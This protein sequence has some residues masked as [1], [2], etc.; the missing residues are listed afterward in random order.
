M[1][2]EGYMMGCNELIT[3]EGGNT[4]NFYK[5]DKENGK[6]ISQFNSDFIMSR[7]IQTNKPANIGCMYLEKNGVVGYH[8]ATVPQ[9]FLVVNGAGIVRNEKEEYIEISSG[10]AV[11]WEKDEWHETKTDTGLMAIVIESEELDPSSFMPSKE[12]LSE[13]K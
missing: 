11:F 8:Q 6:Q 1:E 3:G 9:L 4:M 12:S 10:D 13:E 7:V 5:F 2:K